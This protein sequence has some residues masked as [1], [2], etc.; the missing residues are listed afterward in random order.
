MC[1][2]SKIRY[3][4]DDIRFEYHILQKLYEKGI[5]S[6]PKVYYLLNLLNKPFLIYRYVNGYTLNE[7]RLVKENKKIWKNLKRIHELKENKWGNYFLFS[8]SMKEYLYRFSNYIQNFLLRSYLGRR[9]N[10]KFTLTNEFLEL[11]ETIN[12]KK[13][14]VLVHGD[15]KP[16]N[17]IASPEN[18]LYLIDWGRSRF[19]V[20]EYELVVPY[21]HGYKK[22]ALTLL[23]EFEKID[24]EALIISTAYHLLDLIT[25]IIYDSR[26]VP[27]KLIRQYKTLS[28]SSDAILEKWFDEKAP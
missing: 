23:H 14:A 2:I 13:T 7:T 6:I 21:L 20:K 26:T 22:F 11:I 16:G 10:E 15:I 28:H 17:V 25:C 19:F 5:K 8:S 24:S 4:W 12:S 1:K 9:V 18:Q 3:P 27:L